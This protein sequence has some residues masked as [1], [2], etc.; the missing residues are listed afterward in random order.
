LQNVLETLKL[1]LVLAFD[2]SLKKEGEWFAVFHVSRQWLNC[3]LKIAEYLKSWT[4]EAL[5]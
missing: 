2:K 1:N 3:V 5:F 4:F